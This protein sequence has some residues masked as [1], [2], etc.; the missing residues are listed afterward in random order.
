[1]NLTRAFS[2]TLLLSLSLLVPKPALISGQ[3]PASSADKTIAEAD[4]TAAKLGPTI[5]V[6]AIAEPVTGVTLSP[7]RWSG[8]GAAPAY[9]AVDGVIAPLD[10][11]AYGRPINFRVVLPAAWSRR[12]VQ[13]G[14]GGLNGTIP[15]LTGGEAAALLRDGF[16]S[17][18]SD[19]GHQQGP[20]V[21][22]EWTLSDEAIKN[23]G[24]MQLKKTHDAALVLMQR[25][26][27]ELP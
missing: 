14:G 11:S 9:C 4:C 20:G 24:Y 21:S 25:I 27:G 1:M 10:T 26:Y 8:A 13:I 17:Y 6:N 18:G 5:P 23:L 15:N 12:A 16:A 3:A 22:P 2:A 19:S 7:P